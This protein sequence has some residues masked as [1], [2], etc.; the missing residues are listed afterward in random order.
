MRL[1]FACPKELLE[2]A[3]NQIAAAFKDQPID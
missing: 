1:N 2:K 3:L